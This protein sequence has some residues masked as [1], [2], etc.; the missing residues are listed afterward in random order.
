MSF[1]TIRGRTIVAAIFDALDG[2]Y[3]ADMRE[4]TVKYDALNR[5][6]GCLAIRVEHGVKHLKYD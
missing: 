3:R 1:R 6:V 2:R 4:M 5:E